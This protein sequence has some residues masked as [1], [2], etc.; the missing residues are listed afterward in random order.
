MLF[1]ALALLPFYIAESVQG[2]VPTLNT[3]TIVAV[4]IVSVVPGLG[5][6][7]GYARIQ[8]SL[9]AGSTG[10]ILYLAPSYAA[11]F[12]WILLGETLEPYH[13]AGAALILPGIFLST[14]CVNK[15]N[16]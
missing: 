12:G 14:R 4:L 2:I 10:L 8:R 11:L 7:L 6:Y 9:G 1:G 3:E 13:F 5:A 16:D 15:R